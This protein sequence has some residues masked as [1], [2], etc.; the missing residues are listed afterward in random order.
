[1]TWDPEVVVSWFLEL[2]PRLQLIAAYV[3][4][5]FILFHPVRAFIVWCTDKVM[6]KK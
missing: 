4:G 5:V 2:L 6:G 3:I 1:M